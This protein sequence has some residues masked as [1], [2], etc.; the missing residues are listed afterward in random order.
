MAFV[1]RHIGSGPGVVGLS[2]MHV[3][4]FVP[5]RRVRIE[6]SAPMATI[7]APFETLAGAAFI[8]LAMRL[9]SLDFAAKALATRSRDT[10]SA[11]PTFILPP[12]LSWT[13]RIL[14]AA[15]LQRNP[16]VHIRLQ[17]VQRNCPAAE[18]D[19]VEFAA[20]EARPERLLGARAKLLDLQLAEL[21]RERLSRPG[22]VA[23][24]LRINLVQR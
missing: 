24:D 3:T 4:A 12:E 10:R 8:A 11:I 22:D 7:V 6:P 16:A 23:V 2:G 19:V 20:V 14:S 15:L 1:S 5:L 21:V 18:D 17:H 9:A 13:A